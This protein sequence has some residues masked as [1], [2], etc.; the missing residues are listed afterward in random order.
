MTNRHTLFTQVQDY[1]AD[2]V[3]RLQ[4]AENMISM[5]CLAFEDGQ[6]GGRIADA[7]SERAAAGVIVRLM[8]DEL[9][10]LTDEPRSI[11]SNYKILNEL[12]SAGVQVDV[13]RPTKQG[14]SI[15]NRMHCK[16][17]AVDDETAYL[18]G[19]NVGDYYTTWSDTNLRVD[20]SLGD[21]LHRTYDYLR[22]FSEDGDKVT[23]QLD[24]SDLW[25]GDDRLLL[26]LPG[27]RFDIRSALLDLFRNAKRAIHLRTWYFLPE[28][29]IL[30]SLCSQAE[31]KVKVNVLLSH[32]T[33]V[34][35]VDLANAI[36]VHRLTCSGGRV[37]RYTDSYMHAKTA[38]ND[39][40]TILLGSANLDPHSMAVNFESCLLIQDANLAWQL[41]RTFQ[42]DLQKC[43][44]QT[45]ESYRRQ[46]LPN[47]FMSHACNLAS[48]W[49]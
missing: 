32:R 27:N 45:P 37:Y 20:G 14:L 15:R 49:L 44:Q 36:H 16:F 22:S 2:V 9:G 42:A 12:R 24:L 10:Q 35:L 33:R 34:R 5:T 17:C 19:S 7:L 3:T 29:E 47:K 46:T 21:T 30:N 43:T 41:Q 11:L 38:W 18:G 4:S 26:T 6:W 39:Q 8:V 23:V 28:A 1:Y 13:F 31:N 40:G 25:V 48:P